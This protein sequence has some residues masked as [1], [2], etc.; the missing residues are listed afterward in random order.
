M[1]TTISRPAE[2]LTE[3]LWKYPEQAPADG[4]VICSDHEQCVLMRDGTVFKVFGAGRHH[5]H[6]PSYA[7]IDAFFVNQ[8]AR[9][10][11]GTI[12]RVKDASSG[13][14][15]QLRC[16]G[17]VDIVVDDAVKLCAE[18]ATG[19]DGFDRFVGQ[20]V[21]K[22]VSEQTAAAAMPNVRAF[23]AD[24]SQTQRLLA[25]VQQHL[26]SQGI[27]VGGVQIGGFGNVTIS[28]SPEDMQV[29]GMSGAAPQVAQQQSA[30][31]QPAVQ[32][33]SAQPAAGQFPPG[34]RVWAYWTDGNWYPATV[35]QFGNGQ[36]LVDWEGNPDTAWVPQGHVKPVG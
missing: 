20:K 13:K 3:L 33:A 5:I 24:P 6:A 18:I 9:I 12:A 17:E 8:R 27:G 14:P 35:K 1:S 28:P 2:A 4:M 15:V 25:A 30:A 26:G 23:V 16:F 31:R 7:H 32:Q 11:F 19:A 36:Y 34:T 10:K 22:V 29:L 21:S